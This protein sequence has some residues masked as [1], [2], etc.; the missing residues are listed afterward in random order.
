MK[1]ESSDL[2]INPSYRM[3]RCLDLFLIHTLSVVE[4]ASVN[5]RNHALS[6]ICLCKENSPCKATQVSANLFNH[7]HTV[8][9]TF[10]IEIAY[11]YVYMVHVAILCKPEMCCYTTLCLNIWVVTLTCWFQNRFRNHT[12]VSHLW[13]FWWDF[14]TRACAL[15]DTAIWSIEEV[16]ASLWPKSLDAV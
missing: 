16:V 9:F 3:L 14:S 1:H 2:E 13:Y 7:A 10:K 5:S 8:L 4:T 12:C 11:M 15:C 6:W